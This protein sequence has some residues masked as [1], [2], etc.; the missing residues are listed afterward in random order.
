[1]ST[2]FGPSDAQLA[3]VM[4]AASSLSVEKRE[5]FLQRLAARLQHRRFDDADVDDAIR[6]ALAGPIHESAG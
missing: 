1:M 3:V 6:R 4:D 5:T 2:R